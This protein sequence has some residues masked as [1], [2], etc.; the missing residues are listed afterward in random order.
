MTLF[1]NRI[2]TLFSILCLSMLLSAAAVGISGC[3]TLDG[4]LA[5]GHHQEQAHDPEDKQP[6]YVG[7][8]GEWTKDPVGAD[9][10]PN[11]PAMKTVPNSEPSGAVNA[12][13]SL[14]SQLGPWGLFAGTAIG[15]AVTIY[16]KWRQTKILGTDLEAADALNGF[17]INL[18]EKV[19][20]G[21]KELIDAGILTMGGDGKFNFDQDKLK[22][23]LRSQ[24]KQFSD[25][26]YLS[27]VVRQ[28]TEA[29]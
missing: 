27:A 26:D 22:E 24:G 9:G 19:K 5:S 23:W 28:V 12:A 25:P 1:R 10:I 21:S 7:D 16:L 14:V 3:M 4:F 29:L 13:T 11:P 18:I 20:T 6:W 15:S 2:Y 8:D 17:L